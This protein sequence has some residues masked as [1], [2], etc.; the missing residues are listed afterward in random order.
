DQAGVLEEGKLADIALF[1]VMKL[2]YAGSRAD[3]TASL[4]FCGC[5][6]R[7]DHVIVNGRL[8]VSGGRLLGAD[9]DAI[10][11]NAD[12]AARRLLEKAGLTR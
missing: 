12:R 9:E 1:D 11:D 4:L 2:E 8:A 7:A 10:R 5:D 6:H 3:P